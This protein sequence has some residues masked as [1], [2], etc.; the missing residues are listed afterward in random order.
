MCGQILYAVLERRGILKLAEFPD[1]ISEIVE[2][3]FQA[4]FRD[5]KICF[6][7]ET[8]CVLDAVFIYIFHWRT[9]DGFFEKTAKILFIHV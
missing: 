7:Q 8:D 3:A 9:P 4:D 6:F 1:K 5:G 2:A